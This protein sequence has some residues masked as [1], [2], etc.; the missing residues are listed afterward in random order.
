M[1][2]RI[3][4]HHVRSA[5]KS[6]VVKFTNCRLLRGNQLVN[7]DLWISSRSGKI[8]NGQ[9]V[10]FSEKSSPDQIINLQ[11]RILAPGF[12]ETQMNGAFGF[13]FSAVPEDMV[14][15]AKGMARFKKGVITTG[16][17]SVLPTLTSQKPEVYQR[18]RR[19]GTFA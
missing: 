5:S 4:D 10:F 11:G 6:G 2:A 17:T 9:E 13:D 3:I 7:D 18:V 8:L 19:T 14:D 15:Y 16:V 1:P 12:I